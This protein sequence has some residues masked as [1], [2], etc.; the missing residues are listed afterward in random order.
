MVDGAH[1]LQ[2]V[3]L[4]DKESHIIKFNSSMRPCSP[5]FPRTVIKSLEGLFLSQEPNLMKVDVEQNYSILGDLNYRFKDT[6]IQ[7]YDDDQGLATSME[8]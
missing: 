4:L 3:A 6:K 1:L 5:K 2:L 7:F 8:W